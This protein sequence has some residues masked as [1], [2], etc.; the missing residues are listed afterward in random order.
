MRRELY[1]TF[2]HLGIPCEMDVDLTP[3]ERALLSGKPTAVF[4]VGTSKIV[5][6]ENQDWEEEILGVIGDNGSFG[7][8]NPR[9]EQ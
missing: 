1:E 2:D 9:E 3:S 7:A 4:E 8:G 6:G 5:A